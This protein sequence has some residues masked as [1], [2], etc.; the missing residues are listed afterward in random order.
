MLSLTCKAA[1]KAVVCLGSN[2]ESHKKLSIREIAQQID[3]NEHTVGKLLQKLVKDKI[4]NSTKG[5]KGGFFISENQVHL[6]VIKVI[7]SIDGMRVFKEC[8][9]GLDHCSDDR[10]CPMHEDFKPIRDMF[11]QMCSK[12]KIIDMYEPVNNGLVYLLG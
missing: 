5:P 8:G 9:L 3:E 11:T 2:K 6:P 4:I 1:I 12:K 7:E 10:P